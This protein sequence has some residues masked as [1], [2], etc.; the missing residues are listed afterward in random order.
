MSIFWAPLLIAFNQPKLESALPVP[1]PRVLIFSKTAAFRHDS[2]PIAIAA[3]KDLGTKAGFQVTATE[4]ATLFN[5]DELQKF[6]TVVMLSTTGDVLNDSQQ[7]ALEKFMSQ[8]KGLVGIHASTDCEYDW[9]WYGKTMGAYFQNHPRI[10]TAEIDVCDPWNPSTY[11]MDKTWTWQDEWYNFRPQSWKGIRVLATLNEKSYEGG[12]MG[13]HPIMWAREMSRGRVW[14]TNLGHRAETY[15]QQTFLRSVQEGIFWV[16]QA[17]RSSYF[18]HK[19]G[20]V[21]GDQLFH[22]ERYSVEREEGNVLLDGN[23]QIGLN[24]CFLKQTRDLKDSDLGGLPGHPPILNASRPFGQT[25]TLDVLYRAGTRNSKGETLELPRIVE[26]RVNGIVVQRDVKIQVSR[27]KPS[28]PTRI[29]ANTF[30]IY[31]IPLK[32]K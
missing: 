19:L 2:I 31:A 27:I 16:S 18:N 5:D 14:Y 28:T 25:D 15:A 30:S 29:W 11:F 23:V 6:D 3:L 17:N 26:L 21:T 20:D 12:N 9:G 24:N 7:V 4:D 10:Q 13:Y 8:G 22:L 1:H 32:G